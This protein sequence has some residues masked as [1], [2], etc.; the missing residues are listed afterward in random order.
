MKHL[1][2]ALALVLIYPAAAQHSRIKLYIDC[3]QVNCD[4]DFIRQQIPVADFV[5]D[6]QA[7]DVHVL[8]STQFAANGGRKYNVRL[9]GQQQFSSLT[10]T[11]SFFTN[12]AQTPDDIRSMLVNS[13]SKSLVAFLL[14]SGQAEQVNVTFNAPKNDTAAPVKDKWNY[15]VI[16][17]GGRMNL[18]GDNNYK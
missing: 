2:T 4:L 15:W 1:L 9:I 11:C 3:Q 13:I 16:S 6:R 18:S 7:S 12:S 8:I 17:L 14:K 5:R 10:D